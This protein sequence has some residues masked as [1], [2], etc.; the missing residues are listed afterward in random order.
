MQAGMLAHIITC[1]F[2]YVVIVRYCNRL[3]NCQNKYHYILMIFNI[4]IYTECQTNGQTGC[5]YN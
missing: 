2:T 4:D 3:Y 1:T 5:E